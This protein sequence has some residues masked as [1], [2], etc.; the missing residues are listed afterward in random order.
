MPV[1]KIARALSSTGELTACRFSDPQVDGH[2]LAAG[3]MDELLM[4]KKN[5][6]RH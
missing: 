1:R 2:A 4:C 5:L 6:G 3:R